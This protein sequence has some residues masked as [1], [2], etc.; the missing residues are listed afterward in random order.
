M[1]KYVPM[2]PTRGSVK[3]SEGINATVGW[4]LFGTAS[5]D[6]TIKM[7]DGKWLEAP[8]DE[9]PRKIPNTPVDK[10]EM[11]VKHP[12]LRTSKNSKNDV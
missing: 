2:H 5:I 1:I 3:E 8:L 6:P 12:A 9:K 11:A 7:F 4:P 10:L